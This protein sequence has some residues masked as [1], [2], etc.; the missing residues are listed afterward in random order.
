MAIGAGDSTTVPI[1]LQIARLNLNTNLKFSVQDADLPILYRVIHLDA[2]KRQVAQSGQ[3]NP[4]FILAPGKYRIVAEIG[5]RN[6]AAQ[7]EVNLAPGQTL[8]VKLNPPVGEV[9][10]NL[11][12]EA[13]A[14]TINRFWVVRDQNGGIVWRSSQFAPRTLLA[15]GDYEVSCETRAG[16]IKTSFTLASGESKS[17]ELTLR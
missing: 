4:S 12:G 3:R 1:N 8:Q 14:M 13:S 16:R 10:L 2:N 9:A 17:I 11:S 15:P 7:A 6:V 5:A